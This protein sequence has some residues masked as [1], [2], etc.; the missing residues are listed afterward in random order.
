[1]PVAVG[2]GGKTVAFRGELSAKQEGLT[3]EVL[4][5]INLNIA[6]IDT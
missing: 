1:M 6:S 5:K 2:T 3:S 4:E